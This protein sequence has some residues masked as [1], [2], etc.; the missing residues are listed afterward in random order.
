MNTNWS[1]LEPYLSSA[2]IFEKAGIERVKK[3]KSFKIQ[4]ELGSE[5]S[6]N[7]AIS[8]NYSK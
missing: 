8:F 3:D 1:E 4:C 7:L 2:Q 6:N 5:K